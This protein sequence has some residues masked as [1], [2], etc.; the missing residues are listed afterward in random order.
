MQQI[1]CMNDR[2][3]SLSNHS[4]GIVNDVKD[5]FGHGLFDPLRIAVPRVRQ[6]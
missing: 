1:L 5:F 4:V 3:R 2:S 6:S